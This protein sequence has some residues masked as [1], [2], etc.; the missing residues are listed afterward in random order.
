M[1]VDSLLRSRRVAARWSC[2][3]CAS[4]R[5]PIAASGTAA[6]RSSIAYRLRAS[7]LW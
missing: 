4:R 7:A 5:S 1:C 6:A 2:A 3:R